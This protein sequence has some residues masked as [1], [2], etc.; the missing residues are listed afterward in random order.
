MNAWLLEILA[1][2]ASR[3]HRVHPASSRSARSRP[4]IDEVFDARIDNGAFAARL[5]A[6]AMVTPPTPLP[7][8]RRLI[9]PIRNASSVCSFRPENMM[10]LAMLGPDKIDQRLQSLRRIGNAAQRRRYAELRIR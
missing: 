10:S 5:C 6:Y 7:R 8:P 3:L 9:R 4:V 2:P 1:V